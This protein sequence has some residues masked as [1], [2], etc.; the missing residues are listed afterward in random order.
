MLREIHGKFFALFLELVQRSMQEAKNDNYT[1]LSEIK[2]D[3]TD[4]TTESSKALDESAPVLPP[5]HPALNG[6]PLP[7][8]VSEHVTSPP[9]STLSQRSIDR[10]TQEEAERAAIK[11]LSLMRLLKRARPELGILILATISLFLSTLFLLAIPG[12][13]SWVEREGRGAQ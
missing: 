3:D 5:H 11:K 13:M 10:L 4:E 2:L 12:E 8:E 7:T 9:H 6:S 1:E